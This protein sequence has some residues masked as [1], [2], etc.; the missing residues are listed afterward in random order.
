MK[1]KAYKYVFG[2]LKNIR[3]CAKFSDNLKC[4]TCPCNF[5]SIQND[6]SRDGF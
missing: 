3:L 6:T 4:F 1:N 5:S 2:Q